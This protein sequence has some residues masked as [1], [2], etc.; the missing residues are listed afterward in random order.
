[1]NSNQPTI[2]FP[3]NVNEIISE[4]YNI[5]NSINDDNK[6]YANCLIMV[7]KK[8]HLWPNIKVKKFK[9]R[10]DI[11]LL[12]NNYKMGE[13]YEYKELYEQCRSIVLDFTLSFNDNVV[14]TYANSIPTRID[15]NTYMT[16][17]YSDHDKCYEAYDGTM[18]TVYCH[19]GEWYFGTSSCPDANSSKFSHPNKTH[20]IMLDEILYKYYGNQL[21]S[22]DMKLHAN[23]ISIIL[24]NKFVA[25]LNP[26]MAYE[27]IIIH[28]ENVHIINYT[29]VLGENYKELIHVNT[30]NRRTL[31][32][33][34][35]HTK[36]VEELANIGINYPREFGNITEAMSY[37]NDNQYSYGLII[38]NKIE[39]VV[40]LYKVSTDIINYR[41]ET[42]PCHPNTWMNILSVYM[43]NKQDYTV[44]DYI[45]NYVPN[46]VLP[47]DNNGRPI[48]ATYIIHTLISTIKDSLYNYYVS[49]TTYYPRYGRYK[50]N[51]DLDKQFPPIIQYHL[52]Q[53]RNLQTSTYKDKMITSSNVYYYLCQCNDVKNIKTLIQFFASTPINEMH[54]RTS[55]C[56]AIMNSLIS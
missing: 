3:K 49:T 11:V 47:I 36:K 28:H 18:I 19:N 15:A 44:K 52:A 31:I 39:N 27:F 14:V 9:N 40:K 13:I 17:I 4:T 12:H 30:K 32:E 10:S 41:E 21:T 37:I 2:S 16:N 23:E 50:M 55:M 7:L 54:P 29:N 51:K 24:R 46:I 48:D 26:E 34:D 25:S 53:L 6:T 5:Y 38:K 33:D 45:S 8:Y 35:I 1:M 43:K 22:E 20:G 56:F 42:D